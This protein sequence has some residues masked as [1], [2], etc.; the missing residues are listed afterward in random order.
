MDVCTNHSETPTWAGAVRPEAEF[1]V[2]GAQGLLQLH[3]ALLI[4]KAKLTSTPL[5]SHL[6]GE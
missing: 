4:C 5:Q 2:C 6:L 3:A 1:L